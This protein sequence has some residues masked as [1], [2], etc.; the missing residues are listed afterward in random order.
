MN[1]CNSLLSMRKI[2]SPLQGN[3]KGKGGWSMKD[4]IFDHNGSIARRLRGDL[5]GF[6]KTLC[7]GSGI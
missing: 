1:L 6:W 2:E 5:E 7:S 4:E 3:R